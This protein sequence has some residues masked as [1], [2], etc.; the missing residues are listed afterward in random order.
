MLMTDL[1]TPNVNP[2]EIEHFSQLASTWWKEDGDMRLLHQLNPLR[3]QFI[4]EQVPLKNIR[5]LDVGC[6]GGLLTEALAKESAEVTGLDLSAALIQVAEEHAK[7]VRLPIQYC[8]ESIEDFASTH[9]H[10][11]HLVTCMEMLE[12]VP[13]P[14]Q[15]I[16]AMVDTLAPGGRLI[17]STLN[18]NLKTYVQA[19]LGAEYVLGLLPK[20]T[21]DYQQFIRPSEL[22]RLARA[23]KLRLVTLKGMNYHPLAPQHFSLSD[24]I[25]VNYLA[26]FEKHCG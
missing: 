4:R 21:H 3:L 22:C 7:T 23:A 2:Q 11:F 10:T 19:I 1:H 12:H 9:P 6:G 24:D 17:C 26:C 18:R 5:A 16:Q 20:G 8:C 15:I 13:D 14:A 25:S